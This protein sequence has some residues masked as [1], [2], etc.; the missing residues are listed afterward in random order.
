MWQHQSSV[1]CAILTTNTRPA[2]PTD[3]NFLILY[4]ESS[5]VKLELGKMVEIIVPHIKRIDQ[6]V[7]IIGPV[8]SVS[9]KL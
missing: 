8:L 6:V 4:D 7:I 1:T 9:V 5:F 2:V 3:R